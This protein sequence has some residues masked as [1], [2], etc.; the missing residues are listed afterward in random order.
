M[1]GSVINTLLWVPFSAGK[2]SQ[3]IGH[4]MVKFDVQ[5][6]VLVGNKSLGKGKENVED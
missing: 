3:A 2:P 5:R 1:I 4:Q 6:R